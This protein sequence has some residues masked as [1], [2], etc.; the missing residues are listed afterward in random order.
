MDWVLLVIIAGTTPSGT[1]LNSTN[2]PMARS[3]MADY[4][5]RLIT[6]A[7][8]G[9]RWQ[10]DPA[11]LD[12][13]RGEGPDGVVARRMDRAL[14]ERMDSELGQMAG[15]FWGGY[16]QFMAHGFGFCTMIGDEITGVAYAAGV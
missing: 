9:Y 12:R 16:E 6:V 13:W 1:A 7:R 4:A 10:E 5:G 8:R 14:T 15:A 11:T 2:V 3:I